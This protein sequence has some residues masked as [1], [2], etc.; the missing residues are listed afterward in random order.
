MRKLSIV[1]LALLLSLGQTYRVAAEEAP[2]PPDTTD[3]S[4][5]EANKMIEEYNAAATEY[6]EYVDQYNE[7][8]KIKK[9]KK[10]NPKGLIFYFN[11]V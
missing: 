8:K 4:P 7:R 9:I 11:A 1:L 3:V 10:I 5:T 2:T 6:N